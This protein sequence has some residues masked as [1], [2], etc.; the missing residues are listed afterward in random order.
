M[1]LLDL[2]SSGDNRLFTRLTITGGLA[3]GGSA[4]LLAIVN[5]AAEQIERD[6]VDEVNWFLAGAF[7]AV[8][9]IYFLS[10]IYLVARIGA[11]IENGINRVRTRLLDRLANA[12]FARIE[13]FGQ[14]RLYESI[15][16]SS[17]I[18]SQNSQLLAHAFRSLLLVVAVMLYVLWLSPLAFFLIVAVIAIG[19][20]IY[21]RMGKELSACYHK[22]GEAE[23][24]LFERVADLFYGIKE[25]RMSS[26][27]SNALH[28]AFMATSTE[29]EDIAIKAHD[30]TFRQQIMGMMAFYILLAV[31]VF[32]VPVYSP[33][34]SGTVMKVSTAVLFMIGPISSVV[35]SW[36]VLGMAESA[37]IRMSTLDADLLD[38]AEPIA[39]GN[40]AL[41]RDDFSHIRFHE[42]TF[43]YAHHDPYHG[44]ELGPI[45]LDITRGDLIFITGGNG[46]GKSTLIKLLTALYRPTEGHIEIDG[47]R[48]GPQSIEAYRSLIATVFSDYHLF[49]HLYGQGE[50]NRDEASFWLHL[51]EL[52]HITGI[53]IPPPRE[54]PQGDNVA[55]PAEHPRFVR[56]DLSQ[57]QKK[58]LALI[59]AILEKRPVLVLD[60][61]AADQDPH[62]REKFYRVILPELKTRG[63]TIVAVTHDDHYFDAADR[64]L[65]L[66]TGQL[67]DITASS[68]VTP[69]G[70]V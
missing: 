11:Q 10:E 54:A 32:I 55:K 47:M 30:L 63:Q 57:G 15:T 17:Q 36:T 4:V 8:A 45:T 65:H 24:N 37:A 2:L 1:K 62:F 27:R 66:D 58:R 41:V 64:R 61:W 48:L 68:S 28:V 51:F 6:A 35:Q 3:G 60:E 9:A 38:M 20:T 25:V 69:D 40:D 46:S 34:F 52:D 31:I 21:L 29:K 53:E 44:F 12:D 59:S 7:I 70:R 14:T 5:A 26:A 19:T 33:S 39:D 49:S 13:R 50:I 56:K 22:L 18:I 42:V 16:Q 23:N 67:R 43:S